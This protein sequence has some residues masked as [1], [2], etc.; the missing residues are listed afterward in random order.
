MSLVF[1]AIVLSEALDTCL[2]L[3][4]MLGVELQMKDIQET[5]SLAMCTLTEALLISIVLDSSAD[6]S[7]KKSKISKQFAKLSDAAKLYDRDIKKMLHPR[8]VRETV[9]KL[10]A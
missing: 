10:L 4:E 9:G 6:E 2:S 7:V 8:V 3:A 1:L 5:M